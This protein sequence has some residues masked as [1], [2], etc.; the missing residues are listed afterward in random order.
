MRAG[1][2]WEQLGLTRRRRNCGALACLGAGM[3]VKCMLGGCVERSDVH[4]VHGMHDSGLWV[5]TR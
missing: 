2:K 5:G 4:G 1:A 3:C